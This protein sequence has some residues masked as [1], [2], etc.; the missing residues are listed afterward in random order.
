VACLLVASASPVTVSARAVPSGFGNVAG[1][2]HWWGLRVEPAV[3]LVV[4]AAW[5]HVW[6]EPADEAWHADNVAIRCAAFDLGTG[7]VDPAD[8]SFTLSTSVPDGAA[9]ADASTGTRLICNAAGNCRTAGP[10]S[11]IRVDRAEPE[12]RATVDPPAGPYALGAVVQV[13]FTCTDTA[14]GIGSCPSAAILDTTSPGT[15]SASF[16]AG[17]EAGNFKS[18]GVRYTVQSA[19]S[20]PMMIVPDPRGALI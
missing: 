9:N 15:Y 1:G 13:T 3:E 20:A 8:A 14:S 10:I 18:V 17:D 2:T 7:L 12:I 19:G 11:G 6:C 5:P 4:W 16:G